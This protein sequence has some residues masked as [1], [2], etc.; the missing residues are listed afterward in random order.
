MI[1]H[2]AIE[3]LIKLVNDDSK[4]FSKENI[5]KWCSSLPKEEKDFFTRKINEQVS[6]EEFKTILSNMKLPG[7]F[8]TRVLFTTTEPIGRFM[9]PFESPRQVNSVIKKL[10]SLFSV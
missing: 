4:V 10:K 6:R 7:G 9:Y 1:L 2:P 5:K 8:I 3:N